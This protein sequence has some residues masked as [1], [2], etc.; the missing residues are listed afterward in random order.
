MTLHHC[1]YVSFSF[2]SLEDLGFIKWYFFDSFINWN[3][4]ISPSTIFHWGQQWAAQSG[5][6]HSQTGSLLRQYW[7]SNLGLCP[8]KTNVL[9]LGH[10]PNT[11]K[12]CFCGLFLR[13]Q[14]ERKQGEEQRYLFYVWGKRRSWGVCGLGTVIYFLVLGSQP[15]SLG[16]ILG[17]VLRNHSGWNSEDYMRCQ[18]WKLGHPHANKHPAHCSI[19]LAPSLNTLKGE[20]AGVWW[21]VIG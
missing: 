13:G 21:R 10:I 20:W 7:K 12:L 2:L 14:Q 16:L 8:C 11:L 18:G 5:G 9:P 1:P 3:F 4:F 19:A 15:V 6:S 17:F